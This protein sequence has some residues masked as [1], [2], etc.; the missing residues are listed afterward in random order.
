MGSL[1]KEQEYREIMPE[2]FKHACPCC[3]KP[4]TFTKIGDRTAIKC[5]RNCFAFSQTQAFTERNF[6]TAWNKLWRHFTFTYGAN[7]AIKLCD[8]E[9]HS[10]GMIASGLSFNELADLINKVQQG[11]GMLS[12]DGKV[13]SIWQVMQLNG[14]REFVLGFLPSSTEVAYQLPIDS[15]VGISAMVVWVRAGSADD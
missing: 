9:I 3:Q 10:A 12:K 5:D 1:R 6:E 11:R 14:E 2:S 15:N 8:A 4:W 7:E 13:P